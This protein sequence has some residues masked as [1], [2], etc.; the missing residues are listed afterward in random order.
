[1]DKLTAYLKKKTGEVERPPATLLSGNEVNFREF[2]GKLFESSPA[3]PQ[4]LREGKKI[5]ARSLPGLGIDGLLVK[6]QFLGITFDSIIELQSV[7]RTNSSKLLI[8]DRFLLTDLCEMRSDPN[9]DILTLQFKGSVVKKYH[10]LAHCTADCVAQLRQQ[11]KSQGIHLRSQ[12]SSK[13]RAL[14]IAT[15]Q[16]LL[17]V[18]NSLEC[19][20]VL[21][22]SH[23]L[24]LEVMTLLRHAV[25][26]FGEAND[27]RYVSAVENIQA[28]L[29]R[30]D[31]HD[32]LNDYLSKGGQ[33]SEPVSDGAPDSGE[34][35]FIVQ[36]TVPPPLPAASHSLTTTP[37][38]P[39]PLPTRPASVRFERLKSISEEG[40]ALETN[41]GS[42]DEDTLQELLRLRRLSRAT[43]FIRR[44]FTLFSDHKGDPEED[45]TQEEDSALSASTKTLPRL[46]ACVEREISSSSLDLKVVS[47]LETPSEDDALERG[48]IDLLSSLYSELDGI[49]S[50]YEIKDHRAESEAEEEEEGMELPPG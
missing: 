18:V 7:S 22:P 29:Q 16:N 5:R 26:F 44:E 47:S 21:E 23:H 36:E 28:F 30:K 34:D 45:N 15:A 41:G 3:P 20:F 31:V 32:V 37:S 19:Q 43:S 48:L 1:M 2:P 25:E 42:F 14:N 17:D 39:E 33:L 49:I 4:P 9:Q 10:L 11:L 50:D 35:Q 24:V 46:G 8:G 13:D 27:Q 12:N 40:P 6:K 38:P